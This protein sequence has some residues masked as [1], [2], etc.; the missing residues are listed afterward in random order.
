MTPNEKTRMYLKALREARRDD[1]NQTIQDALLTAALDSMADVNI[2]IPIEKGII[3]PAYV[4]KGVEVNIFIVDRD[5]KDF[6]S[7]RSYDVKTER[8]TTE[9]ED[10]RT[11]I[12]NLCT[13]EFN[14]FE[15]IE[16]S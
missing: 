10:N 8:F 7:E 12:T 1:I 11:Y 3:E 6:D 13:K 2:I 14:E 4:P 5:S 9:K 16:R 15:I